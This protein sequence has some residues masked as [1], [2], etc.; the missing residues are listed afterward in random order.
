[1]RQLCVC[2][3]LPVDITTAILARWLT[4]PSSRD[5]ELHELAVIT[6]IISSSPQNLFLDQGVCVI[7][8]SSTSPPPFKA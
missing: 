4:D 5:F 7:D 3:T 6:A 2:D 1:V 8:M